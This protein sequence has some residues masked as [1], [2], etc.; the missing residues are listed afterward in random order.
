MS[1]VRPAP[2]L[3]S[4]VLAL[5][6][7]APGCPTA[8]APEPDVPVEP[9][10]CGARALPWGP[11][12]GDMLAG[13]DCIACHTEGG[14]AAS[15][16]TI[17]G[18]V[19]RSATCPEPVEGAQILVTD[20]TGTERALLTGPTGNA[21]TEEALQPPFRFAVEMDGEVLEM[22]DET[23]IGSCNWCHEDGTLLGFVY[24]P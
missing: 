8:P 12:G 2:V 16:L 17:A 9:E 5:L 20:A 7:T 6:L 14:H 21:W 3:L 19:L 11:G 13:T 22:Q 23:E 10:E 18:T 1:I 15:T 24:P 4:A